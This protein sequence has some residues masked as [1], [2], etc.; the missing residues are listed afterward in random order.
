[1]D[2]EK[3]S[4]SWMLQ[5]NELDE[6]RLDAYESLVSYK[7]KTK[8]WH[9]AHLSDKKEFAPGDKVLVFNS[10][11]K[12]SPE[13]LKSG[14]TGPYEVK[15]AFSTGYVELIGNGNTFKGTKL[16]RSSQSVLMA[17]IHPRAHKLPNDL[18]PYLV[19]DRTHEN[20]TK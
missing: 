11:F 3:V 12:V 1:M 6:L 14:S 2:L 20:Y 10:R 5:L 18:H 8:R 4:E 13:K 7:E 9:D 19:W 15:K 16:P 17:P